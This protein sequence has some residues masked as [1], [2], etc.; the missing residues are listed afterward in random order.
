ML[1][2]RRPMSCTGPSFLSG[3]KEIG[4]ANFPPPIGADVEA[5][6]EWVRRIPENSGAPTPQQVP[7]EL[8]VRV[9]NVTDIDELIGR[10]DA[11]AIEDGADS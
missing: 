7:F 4:M 8:D 6:R 11:E 1:T 9:I 2:V 3:P 5:W 10:G